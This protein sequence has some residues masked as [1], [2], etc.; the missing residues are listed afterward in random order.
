MSGKLKKANKGRKGQD[1]VQRALAYSC[2]FM[3]SERPIWAGKSNTTILKAKKDLEGQVFEGNTKNHYYKIYRYSK[4]MF[5]PEI[6]QTSPY[7]IGPM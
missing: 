4:D 2:S 7:Y 6:K 1:K 5:S 3:L